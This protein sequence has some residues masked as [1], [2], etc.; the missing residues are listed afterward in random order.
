MLALPIQLGR[1]DEG[2]DF[3]FAPISS[4]QYGEI[5]NGL[6]CSW[7]KF[8]PSPSTKAAFVLHPPLLYRRPTLTVE[9]IP[10]TQKPER[11]KGLLVGRLTSRTDQ[12]D[13]G[14]SAAA[15]AAGLSALR[16]RY[17]L[18]AFRLRTESRA[19]GFKSLVG[20][21]PLIKSTKFSDFLIPYA[22]QTDLYTTSLTTSAFP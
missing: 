7:M 13:G 17:Y 22:F 15:A 11:K 3:G 14:S 21:L 6:F 8:S 2:S 9:R 5:S 1:T 4:D 16:A 20:E 18:R 10:A 19:S 12:R